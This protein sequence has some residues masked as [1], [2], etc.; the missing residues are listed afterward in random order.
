MSQARL[1]ISLYDTSS[2]ADAPYDKWVWVTPWTMQVDTDG[3]CW[4][5]LTA[6]ALSRSGGTVSLPVLRTAEGFIVAVTNSENHRW[7]PIDILG[8]GVMGSK[9]YA[10]VARIEW[11]SPKGQ[12]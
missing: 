7:K 3:F 6:T 10:P 8:E 4:I 11:V 12:S 5:D 2:L 1:P 9:N